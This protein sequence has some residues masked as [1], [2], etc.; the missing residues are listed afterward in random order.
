MALRF[1]SGC[2]EH[3]TAAQKA[4]TRKWLYC[5]DCSVIAGGYVDGNCLDAGITA[6]SRV[7]CVA[8]VT[9]A[10]VF[11]LTMGWRWYYPGTFPIDFGGLGFT[12]EAVMAALHYSS[13]G[14]YSNGTK[15]L[16]LDMTGDGAL[17]VRRGDH[18]GPLL[19]STAAGVLTGATW[20]FIELQ[21]VVHGSSGSVILRVNN[22]VVLTLS[23]LNT[24]GLGVSNVSAVEFIPW[25]IDDAYVLDAS[26]S[27]T[28]YQT[29]LGKGFH[30]RA[31]R[32]IANDE[33]AFLS[34]STNY[35]EVD[36]PTPDGS[37]NSTQ[38][39]NTTDLFQLE[40]LADATVLAVQ[41]N[42]LANRASVSVPA[43]VA[44]VVKIDGTPYQGPTAVPDV[45]LTDARS[46]W[47][48]S[49][50]DGA[51]WTADKINAARW[52]YTRAS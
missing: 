48:A 27:D 18:G 23:G 45:L 33:V 43:T 6:Y 13:T 8:P 50:D 30:V 35:A 34:P 15:Q 10:P 41:P 25:R 44:P 22:S 46:I 11:P 1:M 32:G 51:A 49:P 16:A 7:R 31:L 29:F 36:D 26:G 9:P 19:G 38:F 52:G 12:T 37:K 20:L 14:G 3:L 39:A 42:V 40:T 47:T 17:H 24:S 21:V 28:K 4:S 5:Q 2:G